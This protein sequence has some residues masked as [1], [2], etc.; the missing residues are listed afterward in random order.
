MVTFGIISRFLIH[1][2]KTTGRAG[3]VTDIGRRTGIG[4][5]R[6]IHLNHNDRLRYYDN[7]DRHYT[8]KGLKFNNISN[9]KDN[10]DKND[11]DNLGCSNNINSLKDTEEWVKNIESRRQEVKQLYPL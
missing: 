3:R 9:F 2:F 8:N 7:K 4:V 6:V 5:F 1:N 10:S 11:K